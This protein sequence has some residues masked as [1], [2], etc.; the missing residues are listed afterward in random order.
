MYETV[1]MKRTL[2]KRQGRLS[3]KEGGL[4]GQKNADWIDSGPGGFGSF[5]IMLPALQKFIAA[6]NVLITDGWETSM[7]LT[8]SVDST[9]SGGSKYSQENY[10]DAMT[11]PSRR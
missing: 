11:L 7:W 4:G 10:E 3:A 9:C 5:A 8:D 2:A 1:A 6:L